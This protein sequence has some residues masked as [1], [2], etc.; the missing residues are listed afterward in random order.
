VE[1]TGRLLRNAVQRL[2]GDSYRPGVYLSGGLDSRTIL[3]L[4]ET[5][6]IVSLT[7]GVPDSRDVQFARQIAERVGS[8]HQYF[9]LSDSAWVKEHVGL[10]LE[11]TE[12]FHS[13]IHMHG[14][15]TLET[16]RQ[17]IDVNL[18]GWDGGTVMGHKECIEP[19]QYSAVDDIA[20][21]NRLFHLYNQE[22]TWPSLTESEEINLY[23]P[24]LNKMMRGIAFDSFQEE[25]KPFL[26]LRPDIRGELFYVNNHCRR[27]THHMVTFTRSHVEVRFPF[28]DYDLLDF[29]YAIPA[30]IR[31]HRKLYREVIRRETPELAKIPFDKEG[32]LPTTQPIIEKGYALRVKLKRRFNRHIFPIFTDFKTLY[33]DYENYLRRDLYKWAAGILFDRRTSKRAI[34]SEEGLRSLL[35]R[36]KSGLEEATIGKIAPIMTYEMMLRR[37][38]DDSASGGADQQTF[39]SEEVW[40]VDL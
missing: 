17:L 7:Y 14:M 8:H 6:P 12:G 13:W 19:L 2:S 22:Y 21:T 36:H 20:L 16:A 24:P 40:P 32:F 35:A 31:G 38:Y 5:R 23:A 3:G 29:L 39:L 9:D 34:F 27:L 30:R 25:L 33:V 15:N 10:H 11:L 4:I 37:Y 26:G 28:F 1:E 18:T